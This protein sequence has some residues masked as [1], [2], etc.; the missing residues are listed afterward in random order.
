[1]SLPPRWPPRRARLRARPSHLP[2]P[3]ASNCCESS[4]ACG[5]ARHAAQR[6][7]NS[8]EPRHEN[9]L[10]RL[11][12]GLVLLEWRCDLL[13]RHAEGD[14]GARPRHHL[15]SS[16][17]RS[18]DRPIATSTIPPGPRSSSIR[19]RRRA[20]KGWSAQAAHIGRSA[21]QGQRRR[22]VRCRAGRGDC[23]PSR[24]NALRIYWDVDAPATLDAI[25]ADPTH[26]L[27]RAI[28]RYDAV[29]TYG[30]GDPVVNA[31]RAA[32]ARDCVPIYNALDPDDPSSRACRVRNSLRPQSARQP[33]AGSRGADRSA[34]SS[35]RPRKCRE[36]GFVLGGSGW[37]DKP[38]PANIRRRRPCR[39]RR[40]QRVLLLRR[41]RPQRQSRQH[42]ALRLLAADPRVRGRRRRRLPDHRCVAGHRAVSR[43]GPRSAG[44]RRR[45]G[46]R[47]SSRRAVTRTRAR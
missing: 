19:R 9:L 2:P 4:I 46:G 16:P 34:S 12:P 7:P 36:R 18:S 15:L 35:K 5:R 13:S 26:H 1:M 40:S 42:G 17:T 21:D 23:R 38:M 39:H 27:R 31:Y 6:P 30:G 11:E 44:R 3:R 41:G 20:G 47:R 14:C 32:G 8:K 33:A 24:S 10:L 28:P 29:L 25:A 37:N 45:L 43:A 22:R